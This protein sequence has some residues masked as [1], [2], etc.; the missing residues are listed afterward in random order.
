MIEFWE[1]PNQ[2]ELVAGVVES[3][4]GFEFNY[5]QLRFSGGSCR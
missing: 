3:K 1:L 4:S 5:E 2:S